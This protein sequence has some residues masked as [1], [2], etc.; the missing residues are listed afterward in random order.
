MQKR[1]D[2]RYAVGGLQERGDDDF[3][4]GMEWNQYRSEDRSQQLPTA[5]IGWLQSRRETHR[6]RLR[7]PKLGPLFPNGAGKPMDLNNLRG[8]VILPALKVSNIQWHGWHAFRPGLGTNLHEMG[9]DDL[10]IQKILRHSDVRTTQKCYIKTTAAVVKSALQKFEEELEAAF[11]L[12]DPS[13]T[14]EKQ[15]KEPCSVD[16]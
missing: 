1:R 3:A 14:L 13:V 5:I 8:R 2:S 4:I 9:I 11:G 6:Q 12:T 10:T 7:N 15:P 16:Y